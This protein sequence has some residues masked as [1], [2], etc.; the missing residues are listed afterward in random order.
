MHHGAVSP[1]WF[2]A[3]RD[4]RAGYAAPLG[5]LQASAIPPPAPIS[6]CE[7]GVSDGFTLAAGDVRPAPAPRLAAALPPRE[8]GIWDSLNGTQAFTARRRAGNAR[9]SAQRSIPSRHRISPANGGRCSFV[10]HSTH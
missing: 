3:G 7:S 9:E 8:Q 4:R 5:R 6:L 10:P 1:S 2:Y